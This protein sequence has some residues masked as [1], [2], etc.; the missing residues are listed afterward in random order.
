[1]TAPSARWS[2]CVHSARWVRTCA[3]PT[4]TWIA[5]SA[6]APT[7]SR[8][9]VGWSRCVRQATTASATTMSPTTAATQ[10]CRTCA[11]VT[12]VTAGSSE[13][14]ISGQSGKTSADAGRR[15]V[16]AEQQQR[17]GHG[18]RERREEGEPLARA[19]PADARRV[20][21]PDG[22]EDEQRDERQRG[23]QVRRDRFAA[24]AEADRLAPE[25]RLE[26]DQPDRAEGRPQDRPAVAVVADG[27]DREAEDLEADDRPRRSGGSIRSRPSCRRATG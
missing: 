16:R 15:D 4:T 8:T 20:A 5:N 24:V 6:A 22:Q 18:R 11:A 1:M 27:E 7:A 26:A 19:A 25:P 10:R 12:S 23:G 17:E 2:V 3:P 21:R 13:P 14:P 9:R